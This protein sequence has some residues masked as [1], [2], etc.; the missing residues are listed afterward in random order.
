MLFSRIFA[1][2]ILS[3]LAGGLGAQQPPD[4]ATIAVSARLVVVPAVVRD[5][6]GALVNDLTR[7]NFVLK[8][9]GKPQPLRYFDHDA[10]VPLTLGL[11]IDTSMSQVAIL[12]DERTASTAF[13]NKMIA[14]AD[15]SFVMEFDNAVRLL[16]DV[17]ASRPALDQALRQ[18]DTPHP[19]FSGVSGGARAARPGMMNPAVRDAIL[20]VV[21]TKLF[22]AVDYAARN[23]SAKH[24]GRN[25]LILLTDGGDHGSAKTLEQSVAAA[26]RSDTVIYA[27]YYQAEFGANR[28]ALRDALRSHAGSAAAAPAGEIVVPAS[29]VQS[30]KRIDGRKT[31]EHLCVETGGK[32]FEVSSKQSVA[33]IYAKIAEELRAQY[34][35]GFSPPEQAGAASYHRV[36]LT[37]S[38][39]KGTIQTRDGYYAR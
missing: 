18:I 34:R 13:L 23:I 7:D 33:D 32:V 17:T 1:A 4:V 22:D 8:V 35:L 38:G 28:D 12:D 14:P 39:A 25:A 31:L 16:A 21:G 9:D 20:A 29:T 26:Q 3:S 11:L 30:R 19:D 36:T 27:I 15:Q 37:L 10:D 6:H 2:C 5:K 24:P